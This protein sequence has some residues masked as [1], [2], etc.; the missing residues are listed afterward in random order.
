MQSERKEQ[1]VITTTLV[2]NKEETAWLH[3]VM[4]NPIGDTPDPKY[5]DPVD[6]VMRQMFWTATKP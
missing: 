4:Q 3:T 1:L 6:R 2:L 5:E